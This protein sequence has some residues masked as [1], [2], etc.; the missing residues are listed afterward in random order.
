[1]LNQGDI[2]KYNQPSNEE[3]INNK[4]SHDAYVSE[5][6]ENNFLNLTVYYFPGEPNVV[7]SVPHISNAIQGDSSWEEV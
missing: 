4:T 6:L 5:I 7:K 1:M 2:V 3:P